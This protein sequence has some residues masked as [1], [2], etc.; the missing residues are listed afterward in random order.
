MSTIL[1]VDD[2]ADARFMLRL[3]LEPAG[4]EVVEAADGEAALV[5]ISPE[6]PPDVITTDLAMPNLNGERL[7]ERLRSEPR[8]ASIPI[9][10]VSADPDAAWALQA[11]GLVE[12]VVIKP[13]DPSVLAACILSVAATRMGTALSR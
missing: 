4:H 2:D 7:I 11:S 12:G 3:I 5:F 8:T 13:F 6:S 10:V 9:V 1:V